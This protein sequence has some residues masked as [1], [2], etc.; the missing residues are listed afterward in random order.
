MR[1][2]ARS[3]SPDG[4]THLSY[5]QTLDG[6]E[7][8]SSGLDAHVNRD[9][10][11]ITVN[12]TTV[13]DAKLD[14]TTPSVTALGSLGKARLETGGLALP[15]KVTKSGRST[16]FSTGEAAK[17]RWYATDHGARLAWDVYTEGEDGDAF[18]VVVDAETGATLQQQSLTASVGRANYFPNDPDTTPSVEITMPPSWIDQ[19]A[20]G[21][22][23]WGQ[24]ARTY[25]DPNDQDPAPGLEDGGTR[26]Q[27]PKSGDSDGGPDWLYDRQI[28]AGGTPC[29][30]VSGCSWNSAIPATSMV[31]ERQASTNVHVLTSRY[32]T[33]LAQPPI[34]FDE[35]SGNFQRVNTSG[36][37]KDGDYVRAETNDGQ[38]LNNA[39]FSTPSDG[40]A[41]RM[42]MFL[43]TKVD[44]NGGDVAGIVYHE[45]T[46][47][48]ACRLIVNAGGGCALGSAQGGMMNE[49]WADFFST[50][51]LV[52]EGGLKDTP[53]VGD[54]KL[55][56]HV[57]PGGIRAK[58]TDC[59][60]DPAGTTPACN[61]NGT[62]TTVLG[63]YTYGDLKDTANPPASG[64]H[65][66]GEVWAET[67][68]DLRKAVG[69]DAARALVAGGMRLTPD[70]P[71]FLDARDAILRQAAAMRSA[72][73]APDDY[74]AKA[75][76]VFRARGMGFDA[77]TADANSTT[78][79]ESYAAPRDSL[80]DEPMTVTDAYPGGDNDGKFEPGERI[81]VSAP[82]FSP[83]LTDLS[84]VTGSLSSTDPGVT[85]VD[86]TA[87]WALLGNGRTAANAT[88][89]TARL[90][91]S[92]Y[93]T[94]PLTVTAN[95]AGSRQDRA[96]VRMRPWAQKAV[97][98]ADAP[99][100]A[101]DAV[102]EATFE[103]APGGTIT[104]VDIRI[105]ELRHTYLSDLV[106]DVEHAGET[107]TLFAPKKDWGGDDLVDV[108]FD[109]DAAAAL[110][111][112]GPGPVTGR[113]RTE[114]PNG[115]DK[116]DGKP[117]GG[118]WTLRIT[119][120]EP[121][122]TGALYAWGPDGPRAQFP[123]SGLEIPAAATGDASDVTRD[124][125][126]LAGTVTPNGRATGL[127]FAYGKTEAYGSATASQDV[128]AAKA[129]VAGTAMLTGLEPGTTYHYRVEA[130]REGGVAAVGGGDRTFTTAP[131]PVVVV[132][133]TVSPTPTV[134]PD[135]VGPSLKAT[136][137][138]T[139][140][141]R[142][143]K[144]ATFSLTL[145]EPATVTAVVTRATPGIKKGGKCL[146]G[147]KRKGVRTCTRQV[148]AA[149]GSAA[150]G[151]KS[152][153]L[154]AKGLGKGKYTATLT[155]TDA[156]G[157]KT[158]TVV[159]FSV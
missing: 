152:L 118:T 148:L 55:A 3:V 80:W 127:R 59:P 120:I 9:G 34:G 18:S 39:N 90:P 156:A 87:T 134:V 35:A 17:L 60:V 78:P 6:F 72:P 145:S 54:L 81:S 73:G 15:P 65:N 126:T 58:P 142:K 88:P 101:T 2:V 153:A 105:D 25:V 147:K 66:G 53:V 158:T 8:Y 32:L 49:A 61:G 57:W 117:A 125:A 1:L 45:I 47:G 64:P 131:A 95:V 110:P 104:D 7:S 70:N 115:L 11:L 30:P 83:G 36:S 102:T 124:T 4:I 50:D 67:L 74:L 44:A 103:A 114:E 84:G 24:Y 128:G 28:V 51:L 100:G 13:S 48:L 76:E 97:A 52:A 37:G 159:K 129:A 41:P 31:N 138:L 85:P 46:H 29:P 56:E 116:F 132:V 154:P 26:R 121:N 107:V 111:D 19:N 68:W 99:D 144:R 96:S 75:W 135:T 133:P 119:D 42:Q 12:D 149:R 86:G 151:A 16:T 62:L 146:A 5:N 23:L 40:N 91:N 43:F 98:L 38:G 139:K 109:S 71:S 93:T 150:P 63:G 22:R 112:A 14:D 92:C 155:A 137:K 141:G 79:T 113:Y 77:T 21:T 143:N 10:Q 82:F 20:G 94:V 130:I 136:V 123:C 33:Y 89:L 27:I 106:I 122:D 108:I 157:N 140:A 69:S